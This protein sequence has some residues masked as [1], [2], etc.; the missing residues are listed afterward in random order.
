[1][2]DSEVS[3]GEHYG[4]PNGLSWKTNNTSVTMSE[5]TYKTKNAWIMVSEISN[6][7]KYISEL[8]P[9]KNNSGLFT[10]KVTNVEKEG[11][12]EMQE[13]QKRRQ[14]KVCKSRVQPEF[15]YW[16]VLNL[17]TELEEDS[18]PNLLLWL[19]PD[20]QSIFMFSRTRIVVVRAIFL[21]SREHPKTQI[22]HV[23]L[24]C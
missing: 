1:M 5:I 20:N 17:F 18:E 16:K 10:K 12:K 14:N 11:T 19:Y 15:T 22:K 6:L 3:E 9:F 24:P 23:V 8:W 13:G 7:D 21:A 4:L 2:P